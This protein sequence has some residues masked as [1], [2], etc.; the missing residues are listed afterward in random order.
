MKPFLRLTVILIA[1]IAPALAAGPDARQLV[2]MPEPMR[3]HMLANMRDHLLAITEIQRALG[4]G[5][6]EQAASIAESRVGMSSLGLHG[7]EHMARYMPKPM[8][9]IG[10]RMHRA[11]SQFALIAQETVA[12]KDIR[13]AVTSLAK[14]TEQCVACHAAYRTR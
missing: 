1:C 7:A 9:E 5:D 10:T 8:Q 12:D 2:Q 11:A 14:V 6:L 4:A 13:R 3:A